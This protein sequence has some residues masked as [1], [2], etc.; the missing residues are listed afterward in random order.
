MIVGTK[1][2]IKDIADRMFTFTLSQK[3]ADR[4]TIRKWAAELKAALKQDAD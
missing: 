4:T 3:T 1:K 2:Q